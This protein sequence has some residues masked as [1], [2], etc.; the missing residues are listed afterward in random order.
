MLL[1]DTLMEFKSFVFK[2]YG[3][4]NLSSVNEVQKCQ[5]LRR[6]RNY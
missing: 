4:K 6:E 5:N 3:D 2:I 1:E